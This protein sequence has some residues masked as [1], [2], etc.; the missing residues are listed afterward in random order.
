M[1]KGAEF[2]IILSSCGIVEAEYMIVPELLA[3]YPPTHEK[4]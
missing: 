2:Q 1:H 3:T 4:P